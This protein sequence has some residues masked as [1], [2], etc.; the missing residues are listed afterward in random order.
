MNTPRTPKSQTTPLR[1]RPIYPNE[2]LILPLGKFKG[3][4]NTTCLKPNSLSL[5]YPPLYFKL[6]SLLLLPSSVIDN[7]QPITNNQL[8]KPELSELS[9]TSSLFDSPHSICH[10]NLTI[11]LRETSQIHPLFSISTTSLVSLPFITSFGSFQQP[12]N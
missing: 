9:L 4:L 12:S 1:S 11:S 6:G 5:L 7:N 3:A 10:Q 8:Y 2:N